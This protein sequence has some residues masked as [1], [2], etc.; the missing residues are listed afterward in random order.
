MG[1]TNNKEEKER[2]AGRERER[3]K[4]THFTFASHR[5]DR[6]EDAGMRELWFESVSFSSGIK[7]TASCIMR[8]TLKLQ[9]LALVLQFRLPYCAFIPR[10]L[11]LRHCTYKLGA[12]N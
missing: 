7:G 3:E 6:V 8:L 12:F 9:V 10:A 5:R 11:T 4:R 1:R 2:E